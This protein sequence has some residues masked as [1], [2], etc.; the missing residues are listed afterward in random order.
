MD[1][2]VNRLKLL[3]SGAFVLSLGCALP[4]QTGRN[5][6]P[7]LVWRV[8]GEEIELRADDTAHCT[9]EEQMYTGAQNSRLL[10]RRYLL[11]YAA[12]DG[13]YCEAILTR[14][15]D[16]RLSHQSHSGYSIFVKVRDPLGRIAKL[17]FNSGVFDMYPVWRGAESQ[18][19]QLVQLSLLH[20]LFY[21]EIAESYASDDSWNQAS[22]LYLRALRELVRW[23]IWRWRRIDESYLN[24]VE[25]VLMEPSVLH[26]RGQYRDSVV[27]CREVW[28]KMTRGV[29]VLEEGA[30]KRVVVPERP[31]ST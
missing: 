6:S 11:S 18:L 22:V 21:R 14:L 1:E 5:A 10:K 31:E 29:T 13:R 28:A 23:D 27:K 25:L 16:V 26:G 19:E 17:A 24:D 9:L 15:V 8:P 30:Y 20:G 12:E 4:Q 3:L 7:W 2:R